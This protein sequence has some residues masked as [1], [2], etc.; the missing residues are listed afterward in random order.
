M[1]M[2]AVTARSASEW[3][4]A[5]SEAFVP[6]AVRCAARGFSANLD[7]SELGSGVSV[8][9]VSSEGSVVSRGP[10]VIARDPR[11]VLL[12]SVHRA[13]AGSVEQHG[14]IAK[15]GP[16]NAAA[17]DASRPY[18]LSFPG[19]ISQLVLQVPRQ[20]I[21]R[22]G[23]AFEDLTVTVLPASAS[24]VSLTGLM[25]AIASTDGRPRT[26]AEDDVLA[27][28]AVTL[29]RGV[30]LPARPSATT[31]ID[32]R[33]LAAAMCAYV[34]QHLADPGLTVDRLAAQHYVSVR[35][36]HKIFSAFG[37]TPAAYVRRTR[38][39]RARTLLLG[40]GTVTAVAVRSGFTD[41]ETFTRAFKR[42]YGL[43]PSA[44]RP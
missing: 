40:G 35:L 16:G 21:A 42:E 38:L 28:A 25:A 37:E 30:L 3:A 4:A 9:H 6:L 39:A 23:D 10:G 13:G 41:A 19:R 14:R 7:Q 32:T 27:D 15:L 18:T 2:T 12:V 8:T 33:A 31:R 5:C 17:Y 22:T 29:L 44:M 43:P 20:A 24:L 34:D 36:V 26:P 11:D 1:A